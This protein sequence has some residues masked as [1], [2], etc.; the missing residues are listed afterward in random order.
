MEFQL[1]SRRR[2]SSFSLHNRRFMSQVMWP[3]HWT[4]VWS[5]RREEAK[6]KTPVTSPLFW[7]FRPPTPTSIDW[8]RWCQKDQS[9]HDPLLQNCHL[10][11]YQ[12]HRQ[13]HK[14][15]EITA[16]PKSIML[17]SVRQ[18]WY[19]LSQ[20]LVMCKHRGEKEKR[21]DVL[22]KQIPRSRAYESC[23]PCQH[24]I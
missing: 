16:R 24:L 21:E 19:L 10:S 7:L 8:R 1:L 13:Q 23:L 17:D 22:L 20:S 6:N 3:R 11:G 12:K 4:R 9:K 14:T 2:S 18:K 15:Q 5:A